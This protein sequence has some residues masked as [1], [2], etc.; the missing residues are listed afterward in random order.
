M[1]MT[2]Q[3]LVP[4]TQNPVNPAAGNVSTSSKAAA[5]SV[6]GNANGSKS[7]TDVLVQTLNGDSTT[8]SGNGTI[9]L[10]AMLQ[11]LS[12]AL[13]MTL[14][15]QDQSEQLGT[16]KAEGILLDPAILKALQSS[17]EQSNVINQLIDSGAFQQWLSQVSQLLSSM[18]TGDT[19][20]TSD[21]NGT[22]SLLQSSS[23]QASPKS[24]VQAQTILNQFITALSQNKDSL[25]FQQL[26][27]SFQEIV[28]PVLNGQAAPKSLANS[29]SNQNGNL[30]TG[31]S[32]KS[33]D[34]VSDL[35]ASVNAILE[36]SSN[37]TL[38][39]KETNSDSGSK[40]QP[41]LGTKPKDAASSLLASVNTILESSSNVGTL[42]TKET[43]SDLGLKVQLLQ[44]TKPFTKLEA[45][46]AKSGLAEQLM[47]ATLQAGNSSEEDLNADVLTPSN[48][49]PFQELS[50]M[51]QTEQVKS[52]QPTTA[53]SFVQDMSQ[54][55]MKS[56]KV[57]A[58]NGFSEAR[59]TLSPENLGQVNVKLTMHNGQLVAHFTAQSVLGKEMLEGQL[60]QLKL[61]LQGQGLQVERLEVTQNSSLQSSLFQDQRQQQFSQQ[62][63]QQNK[64][65]YNDMDST[66]ESFS[67]EMANMVKLRSAYG[68]AFDVTA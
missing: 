46:S 10:E 1:E 28:S 67:V 61:S 56:F 40:F 35:L 65:R 24:A 9:G 34:A 29:T 2:A 49:L 50:R 12:P 36:S 32:S 25:L 52:L 62:F 63:A 60:S 41:L 22:G 17:D 16:N 31:A 47:L 8:E 3:S 53:Q 55:V 33:K 54:F 38:T 57:D 27:E 13:I 66:T 48:T 18:S 5:Q 64:S 4:A 23:E 37:G 58:Q 30:I 43:N 26:V 15:T 20:T 45:L 44:G 14:L 19:A 39:T 68:N 21:A 7:F 51:L 6:S 11:G 42:T 59:L